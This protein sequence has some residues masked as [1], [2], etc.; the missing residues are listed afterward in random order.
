[1]VNSTLSKTKSYSKILKLQFYLQ[2]ALRNVSCNFCKTPKV[3][4]IKSNSHHQKQ[5]PEMFFKKGALKISLNSQENSCARDSFLIMFLIINVI[6]KETLAQVFSC[7]FC[8]IFNNT[9]F[10]QNTSGGCFCI[11]SN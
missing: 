10:S 1:M 6:K 3:V 4:L 8:E 11:I 2:W 7:E 5:P 9:F